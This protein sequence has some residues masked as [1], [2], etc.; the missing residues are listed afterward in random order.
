MG[1]CQKGQDASAPQK[2]LHPPTK[3]VPKEAQDLLDDE[4]YFVGLK[5]QPAHTTKQV[6]PKE[7]QVWRNRFKA[8]HKPKIYRPTITLRERKYFVHRKNQFTLMDFNSARFKTLR[9]KEIFLVKHKVI[10][11][12]ELSIEQKADKQINSFFKKMEM[13]RILRAL[14]IETSSSTSNIKVLEILNKVIGRM[15]SVQVLKIKA[16]VALDEEVALLWKI[17]N[18]AKYLNID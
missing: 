10:Q 6:L 16:N 13:N 12:L 2:Y 15:R 4:S 14:S 18:N 5:I 17:V 3:K 7:Q 1:N 8:K 11:R 9:S